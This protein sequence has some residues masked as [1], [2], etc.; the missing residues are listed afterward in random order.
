MVNCSVCNS[1]ILVTQK[2]IKCTNASCH[3][4]FHQ[5][6]LKNFNNTIPRAVWTCAHCSNRKRGITSRSPTPNSVAGRDIFDDAVSE[7]GHFDLLSEFRALRSELN[8]KLDKQQLSLDEFNS[9][10]GNIRKE[11]TE[12]SSKFLTLRE[13]LDD[14]VKAIQF[15]STAQNEQSKELA[16][17]SGEVNAL[18]L[19]NS[20]LRTQIN[21]LNSHILDIEQRERDCNLEIQ[22]VPEYKTENLLSIF[23]KIC[24]TVSVPISQS[25]VK[26]ITRVAKINSD[27]RRPRNIVVRLPST[28]ERDNILAAINAFNKKNREDKLNTLHLGITGDKQ[29]IYITEHLSPSNKKLHAAS[30][31]FV[32]ENGYRFVWIRNG[33]IY[34]RKDVNTNAILVK[35]LDS[36]K[37]I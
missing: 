29:P 2:R 3:N 33:R 36:L 16:K 28:R 25:D 32:K 11:I 24:N 4:N 13:D 5:D 6:C 30:R 10:L 35:N 27:S 14:A 31:I 17:Q 12:L 9:T 20:N 34:I 15:V 19:E 26:N 18:K 1:T 22:C 23:S 37:F 8:A 21:D 7:V